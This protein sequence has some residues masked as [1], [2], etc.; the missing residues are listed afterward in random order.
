MMRIITIE[1]MYY[2]RI[3]L[4]QIGITID[5]D[6]KSTAVKLDNLPLP[7]PEDAMQ[8]V[9]VTGLGAVTP[10]GLGM[11]ASVISTATN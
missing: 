3:K 5:R 4:N 8:R 11:G 7:T 2:Y 1:R 9:V 10:L 6:I